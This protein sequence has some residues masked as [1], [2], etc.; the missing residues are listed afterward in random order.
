MMIWE[1]MYCMIPKYSIFSEKKA[2]KSPRVSGLLDPGFGRA[3]P[4]KNGPGGRVLQARPVARNITNLKYPFFSPFFESF[5]SKLYVGTNN[6]FQ[7]IQP[8]S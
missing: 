8:I 1:I 5:L 3:G 6:E 4:R 2:R 7:K